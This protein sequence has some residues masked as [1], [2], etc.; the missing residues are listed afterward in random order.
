MVCLLC[1]YSVSQ[2]TQP[3]ASSA[4]AREAPESG[5][6]MYVVTPTRRDCPK[7]PRCHTL[8]YY[9]RKYTKELSNVHFWFL[10]GTHHIYRVWKIVNSRNITLL[11]G[12]NLTNSDKNSGGRT[13]IVCRRLSAGEINV[14]NS[15]FTDVE[16]ITFAHCIPALF[17]DEAANAFVRSVFVTN[18]FGLV[19]SACERFTLTKSA[20]ENYMVGI[21]I[22][23]SSSEIT[24]S[25]MNCYYA[26]IMCFL[27]GGSITLNRIISNGSYF[28]LNLAIAS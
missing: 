10:P 7:D 14:S 21:A 27:N 12:K 8:S 13:K 16:N 9:A 28:G 18:G 25:R 22:D 17:F 11:G 1:P 5:Q 23:S 20:F 6:M 4:G 19:V 2:P 15:N 3:S 26:N 24:N